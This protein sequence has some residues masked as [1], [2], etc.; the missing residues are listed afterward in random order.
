MEWG[1][2]RILKPERKSTNPAR[3]A[4]EQ[5]ASWKELAAAERFPLPVQIARFVDSKLRPRLD[6]LQS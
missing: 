2:R 4:M 3:V 6:C 5:G 1:K